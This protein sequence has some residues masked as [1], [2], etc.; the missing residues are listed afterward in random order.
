MA[1]F[2]LNKEGKAVGG[3]VSPSEVFG[4]KGEGFAVYEHFSKTLKIVNKNEAFSLSLPTAND[5]KLYIFAP[6]SDGFAAIGRT[7]KFI[8][9]KTIKSVNGRE[10][11]LFEDGEYAVVEDGHLVFKKQ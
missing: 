6:I 5:Y 7:D 2:N 1:V 9:P 4:L 10:V 11:T 3:T 8:S